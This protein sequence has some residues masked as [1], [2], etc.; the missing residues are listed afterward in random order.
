MGIDYH[1]LNFLRYAARQKPFGA[2]ATI[3]RQT[4]HVGDHV[5]RKIIE[6][7]DG[8]H[9]GPFCEDLLLNYMG[10]TLV[11]S[12][13]NSNYEIATFLHDFNRPIDHSQSYDTVI[14]FGALEHIFNISTALKNVASLCRECGQILHA[15]P[16]NNFNRHGFW[17][18]S[19]E[20]FF[21]LYSSTNGFAETEIFV[22]EL[23]DPKHWHRVTRPSGGVRV[24]YTSPFQSYL[25]VRT[26]E[27]VAETGDAVQQS[28]YL[29]IWEGASPEA[30][31]SSNN[32]GLIS[33]IK[34]LPLV[35]RGFKLIEENISA[36][37]H[38]LA[39]NR[40][41]AKVPIGGPQS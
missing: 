6:V 3:G 13:D 31:P 16:A 26:K 27:I 18:F 38:R 19:A 17:Q 7:P 35:W 9:Y 5:I 32:Q 20:L 40:Q 22:A 41:F 14:D 8:K 25:L 24:Q 37:S 2:T 21:S 23:N 15:L 4:I 33:A 11:H 36:R 12:F 29:D 39:S 34:R 10:S 28:D 30:G 1:G